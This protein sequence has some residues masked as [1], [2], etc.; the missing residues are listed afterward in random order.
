[1]TSEATCGG[2]SV[3]RLKIGKTRFQWV[4]RGVNFEGRQAAGASDM[5][6]EVAAH[7]G[8]GGG[9]AEKIADSLRGE[10]KE[11]A[12]L[13]PTD[14]SYI[15]E[16]HFLGREATL[17]LSMQMHLDAD[18]R[19][20]DIGSGLGG[21]ARTLATEYACHVT[22]I[23]LTPAYCEVAGVMSDW[24]GLAGRTSFQLGDATELPFADR[25]F[26]AAISQHAAMNIA[27]RD[28]LYAE[29]HRVLVPG[30]RFAIYDILQGEGG[31]PLYPAPWAREASMPDSQYWKYRIPR[32]KASTG[33]GRERRARCRAPH[34]RLPRRSCSAMTST[35]R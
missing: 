24:V 1:M 20:L 8:S 27:A 21:A 32:R 30:G 33:C 15:D 23:D 12:A 13:R 7:Y 6:D 16:F 34:R 26:D 31:D 29:A 11:L 18:S 28:R 35:G 9:L 5:S 19:V 14:L 2:F 25:R 22:G 4:H 3:A 10:G 17:R